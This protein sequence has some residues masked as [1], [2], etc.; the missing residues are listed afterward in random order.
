[1][2]STDVPFGMWCWPGGRAAAGVQAGP[3]GEPL[4]AVFL[5][6]VNLVVSVPPFPDGPVQAARFLRELGRAADRMAE[7]LQPAAH[8]SVGAHRLDD[9]GGDRS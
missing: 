3:T 7:L 5:D 4:L 9:V 8:R 2:T 1:M 6:P